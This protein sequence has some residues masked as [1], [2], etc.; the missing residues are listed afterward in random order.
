MDYEW[1]G[2]TELTIADD[3]QHAGQASSSSGVTRGVPPPQSAAVKR[4][5]TEM[6]GEVN[7]DDLQAHKAP[8]LDGE[9]DDADMS[10]VRYGLD[11]LGFGGDIVNWLLGDN[12]D[13]INEV[14][15]IRR[16]V[17]LYGK[18][19][20]LVQSH[21]SE[22]YSPVRVTGMPENMG[23]GPNHVRRAWESLGFQQRNHASKG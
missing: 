20:Q 17:R 14:N 2:W 16:A 6:S 10:E 21:V 15:E 5:S 3:S 22:A 19:Q 8:M 12:L 1:T 13:I 11:M 4:D 9:N 18:G 7:N 23:H